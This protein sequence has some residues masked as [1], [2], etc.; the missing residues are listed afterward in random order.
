MAEKVDLKIFFS[1]FQYSWQVNKFADD[2]IK[3]ADLC[4]TNLA[5]NTGPKEEKHLIKLK[6]KNAPPWQLM[7]IMFQLSFFVG[8]DTQQPSCSFTF[9]PTSSNRQGR[10]Y[11]Y[12]CLLLF[13]LGTYTCLIFVFR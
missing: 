7:F 2:W 5:I 9:Y 11:G 8:N 6:A 4:S 1:Y 13:Y 10:W 12:Y 3:T